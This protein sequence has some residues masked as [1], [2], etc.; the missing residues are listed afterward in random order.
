MRRG[1]DPLPF[2]TNRT[3]RFAAD[4]ARTKQELYRDNLFRVMRDRLHAE[5]LEFSCEPY[6]GP[7]D[8]DECAGFADRVMTEFWYREDARDEELR[9]LPDPRRHAVVEAEAFS[10]NPQHCLFSETPEKL[11]RIGDVRFAQGIGRFHLHTNPLQPFGDDVRPGMTMGPWGS[12][13]GRTQTWAEDAKAWFDYLARSQALLQWGRFSSAGCA[14]GLRRVTR[15]SSDGCVKVVYCLNASAS[16]VRTDFAEGRWFDAVSGEIGAP[17]DWLEPDECGFLVLDGKAPPDAV[18]VTETL[19]LDPVWRVTF[20]DEQVEVS[21]KGCPDWTASSDGRIR[22]YSGTAVYRTVFDGGVGATRLDLGG[23]RNGTARVFLNGRE[24]GVAWCAPWRVAVPADLVR[25]R[26]N[27]LE[28]RV[29]NCW[30]NRMIGDDK[31]PED[32]EWVYPKGGYPHGRHLAR[33]PTWL[34]KGERRP[35]ARRTLVPWDMYL[36]W[37]PLLPSGLVGPVRLLKF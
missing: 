9:Y 16:R 2:L 12:H 21:W 1:Y 24:L 33:W 14:G 28:I 26:G 29:T 35:T 27:E 3:E 10:A 32:C 23:V 37:S 8:P 22:H 34:T 6:R 7:F 20:P 17:P 25:E 13:F 15:V 19:A 36:P 30:Q 11:K 4:F 31:L 18:A 5:G